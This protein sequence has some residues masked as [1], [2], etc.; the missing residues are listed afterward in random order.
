MNRRTSSWLPPALAVLALFCLG[1]CSFKEP[2]RKP[3]IIRFPKTNFSD[4]TK[5]Q[6][7]RV[8]RVMMV[9]EAGR[10]VL[11]NT[12]AWSSPDPGTALKCLRDGV[13]SGVVNV[14][15]ERRGAHVTADIVTGNPQRGDEVFE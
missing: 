5:G 10:F 2:I 13:E 9:S 4:G 14:G 6:P 3:D 11:I 12:D 1:G 15:M 7:R 8:G